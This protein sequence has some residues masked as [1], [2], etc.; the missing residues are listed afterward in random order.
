MNRL[1]LILLL[2]LLPP[3]GIAVAAG[4]ADSEAMNRIEFQVRAE[5]E[6]ANDLSQATLVVESEHADPARLAADINETM[7]WALEQV[8]TATEVKA[9]SGDYR[10][11]PVYNQRR[12]T[13]WRATQELTLES[14]RTE[15]LNTLV[16][17]LQDRLQVRGMNYTV[18]PG[19]RRELEE[20]L[21]GEALDR[22]RQ[23]AGAIAERL[24][25]SSYDIVLLQV[26][27][28]GAQPPSPL[29]ARTMS[30]PEDAAIASEPGTSRLGVTVNAVI[31]LRF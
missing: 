8:R 26:H 11:W 16:G 4:A 10:T 13:N 22:F 1:I 24:G 3:A 23:R 19:Q 15:Q 30:L 12:I 18:S 14:A 27:D 6:A 7:A 9:R 31:A 20:A 29:M 28:G 17:K 5:R 21:T 2:L 25:A